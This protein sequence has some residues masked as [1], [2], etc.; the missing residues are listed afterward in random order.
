MKIIVNMNDMVAVKLTEKGVRVLKERHD[1]LRRHVPKLPE[2]IG[3][4]LGK[5]GRYRTQLWSLMHEFGDSTSLGCDP[6]FELDI[7]G[8]PS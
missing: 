4:T 5:D 2:W 1:E 6:C 7:E 8:S 3:P